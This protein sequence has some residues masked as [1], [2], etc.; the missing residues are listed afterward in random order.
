[1]SYSLPATDPII[2]NPN[3]P[4]WPSS[5]THSPG[6]LPPFT[7]S[8]LFLLGYGLVASRATSNLGYLQLVCQ[9]VLQR[10]THAG[11]GYPITSRLRISYMACSHSTSNFSIWCFLSIS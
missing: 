9:V 1:C 2:C 11:P 5:L 3:L 4:E 10:G 8:I 7:S 6:I